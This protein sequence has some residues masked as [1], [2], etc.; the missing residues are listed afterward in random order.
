MVFKQKKLQLIVVIQV[1]RGPQATQLKRKRNRPTGNTA[2]TR[3]P[4]RERT[5]SFAIQTYVD[6]TVVGTDMKGRFMYHF[7]SSQFELY[8]ASNFRCK[9]DTE[10][11]GL[12]SRCKIGIS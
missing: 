3:N 7:G 6:F 11:S 8:I 5:S 12:V 4:A 1:A 10:D 9:Y 2:Q